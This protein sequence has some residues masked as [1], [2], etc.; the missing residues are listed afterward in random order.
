VVSINAEYTFTT[1]ADRTLVAN[2]I[3]TDHTLSA[4]ASP[5]NGGTVDGGGT[6]GHGA[7]AT[8]T[9]APAAGFFF[10]NWTLGEVPAGTTNPMDFT[11]MGDYA[12]VANF[13]PVPTL[14]IAPAAGGALTVS[15]P[16]SATGWVLQESPDLSPTS[17]ADSILSVDIIGGQNQIAILT[18]TGS[19]FFRLTHP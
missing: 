10:S 1:A 11:V 16:A 13:E 14:S 17:W 3:A 8:L 2:F 19:R 12:F 9:A 5:L 7:L 18:S 15:W 6:F 4:I